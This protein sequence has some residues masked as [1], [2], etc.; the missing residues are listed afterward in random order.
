M[1][2]KK[3]NFVKRKNGN[4][5]LTVVHAPS[6]QLYACCWPAST[7]HMDEGVRSCLLMRS[8]WQSALESSSQKGHTG[9]ELTHMLRE[10]AATKALWFFCIHPSD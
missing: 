5:F 8:C 4:Q 10:I 1:T 3:R 9:C 6:M 2:F 7:L